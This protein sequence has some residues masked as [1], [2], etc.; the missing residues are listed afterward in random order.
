MSRSLTYL[1]RGLLGA[2]VAGAIGFGA[3]AAVAK[4][5]MRDPG[6]ICPPGYQPCPC[7][8]PCVTFTEPCGPC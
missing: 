1:Y 8:T 3:T 2:A 7:N 4:P 5:G 6:P